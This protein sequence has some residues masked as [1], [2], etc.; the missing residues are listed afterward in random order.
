MNE[1]NNFTTVMPDGES[2]RIAKATKPPKK[3]RRLWGFIGSLVGIAL[4]TVPMG[5]TARR[6]TKAAV[7]SAKALRRGRKRRKK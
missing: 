2:V 6:A 1:K 5:D 7:R 4:D 3:R